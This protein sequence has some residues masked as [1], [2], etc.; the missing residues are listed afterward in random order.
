MKKFIFT[1]LSL[2]FVLGT[3]LYAV[4]L[5][6]DKF[7]LFDQYKISYPIK[8]I[9]LL[10]GILFGIF[11]ILIS[12]LSILSIKRFLIL[13]INKKYP[14]ENIIKILLPALPLML[15]GEFLIGVFIGGDI[16]PFF[17]FS[18]ISQVR[19]VTI[20]TLYIYLN[21]G[22]L[23]WVLCVLLGSKSVIILNSKIIQY[24]PLLTK[25]STYLIKD[26]ASIESY[27]ESFYKHGIKIKFNN[28]ES[29]KIVRKNIASEVIN[30]LNKLRR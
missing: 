15:L 13:T 3:C 23:C 7:I 10:M 9:T 12:Y 6:L 21:Y 30:I 24:T 18:N 14:D 5:F 22:I 20:N 28:N 16:L 27:Q 4:I 8:N 29:I 1:I 25:P 2:L 17:I 19:M 26:I 11:L